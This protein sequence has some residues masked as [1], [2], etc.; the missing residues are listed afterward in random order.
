MGLFDTKTSSL[1]CKKYPHD[2]ALKKPF[3][4]Q[5]HPRYQRD[6]WFRKI[7][8]RRTVLKI[9]K[10]GNCIG[11]SIGVTGVSC[12]LCQY[13]SL[14]SHRQKSNWKKVICCKKLD[15]KKIAFSQ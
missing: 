7:K 13:S 9:S 2:F 3:A 6:I 4:S 11:Q 14:P 10:E 12:Y 8:K 5:K 1:Q 15:F